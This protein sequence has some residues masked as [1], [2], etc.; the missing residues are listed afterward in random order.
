MSS[1]IPIAVNEQSIDRYTLRTISG[2]TNQNYNA[3]SYAIGLPTLDEVIYAG[4]AVNKNNTGYFMKGDTAYWTMTPLGIDKTPMMATVSS[5]GAITNTDA[6]TSKPIRPVISV[7]Q[8]I[9]VM[10]GNGLRK[11]PYILK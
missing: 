8:E 10:S 11:E 1:W 2:G 4:G 9:L 3:L 7:N 6:T 5:E